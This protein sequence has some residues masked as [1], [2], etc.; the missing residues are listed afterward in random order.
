MFRYIEYTHR[1]CLLLECAFS[2]QKSVLNS[3]FDNSWY[4]LKG[5]TPP[6]NTRLVNGS[7]PFEGAVEIFRSNQWGQIC[8]SNPD[9]NLAKVVCRSQGYNEE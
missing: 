4:S 1:F 3:S 9:M 6:A 5:Q 8:D 2:N 7:N